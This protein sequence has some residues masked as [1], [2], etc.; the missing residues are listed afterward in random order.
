M[1]ILY[2]QYSNVIDFFQVL[3]SIEQQSNMAKTTSSAPS[4]SLSSP[5][6][7]RATVSIPQVIG[8]S[9][10]VH[11]IR[12]YT[13]TM[14]KTMTAQALVPHFGYC[15]EIMFDEVI[16]L[17]NSVKS[18]AAASGVKF[19]YLPVVIKAVSLALL[20]FPQLNAK[21]TQDMSSLEHFAS[22]NIG[23]DPYFCSLAFCH[24]IS[25]KCMFHASSHPRVAGVAMATPTGL[26]VPNVKNVQAL[27]LLQIASELTRLTELARG[28][29]VPP[30]D[31]S[32][33]TFSLSNIGAIGGTYASPVVLP[34][35]LAI[36]AL[37]RLRVVPRWLTYSFFC[38]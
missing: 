31:L 22:H 7:P 37:G 20:R 6:P 14:I 16:K 25:D 15:D 32:G 30:A 29:S 26:V 18:S 13:R 33:G 24:F 38:M 19:S 2:T 11:P 28:G 1:K 17:R 3:A 27:S 12:G 10:S 9:N 23:A 4:P 21:M 8:S 5:A 34:G 35:E 36:G